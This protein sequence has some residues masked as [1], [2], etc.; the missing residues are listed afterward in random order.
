[1]LHRL[2]QRRPALTAFALYGVAVCLAFSPFW[3]GKFLIND[4]SDMRNGYAFRE[5]AADYAR[6]FGGFPEWNPYIFGGMPFLANPANGDTFYPTFLLRLVLPVDVGIT[7]GFML[8]IALA[9]LFTFLLLRAMRLE[10]GAAFVGGAAY[11]FGGQVLSLVSP[12][13]DGKLFVSALLPLALLC[14]YIGVIRADWRRFVAFG[15]VVG[16]SLLSP[17][18]QMTYYLLMASGFFLAYLQF[19]HRPREGL[20][21]WW[22]SGLFFVGALAIGFAIDAIQLLPFLE[23]IPFSPRGA[24]GRPSTGWEFATLFSMPPEELVN[25]VWPEFSGSIQSYWGRNP[26][27]LHSEYLGVAALLLA[28]F[29]FRAPER[30]PLAWFFVFV[31]AYALL[32]ALGGHTPFYRIPY[33]ILPGLKLTRAP[34]MIF[35]ITGLSVAVLA[36]FGAQALMAGQG[37]RR[38]PLVV[39]PIVLGVGALLA[40]SGAWEAPMRSLAGPDPAKAAVIAEHYKAFA[41]DTVRGLVVCLLAVAL[42]FALL[43]GRLSADAWATLM[44]ALVL[45][46]LWSVERHFIQFRERPAQS[47]AADDIVRALRADTSLYRLLPAAD[48][49]D[50]YWMV[51]RVRSTNGYHGVELHRYDDLLGGKNVW[52]NWGNPVVWQLLAVKYL[53][54]REPL[55]A[56]DLVP[57]AAN[58]VQNYQGQPV[59]FYRY[60][61]ALPWA[62]LVPEALKIPDDQALSVLTDPRFDP[63]RLLLVPADAPVG[64]SQLT[65]LPEPDS[66][67]VH[68]TATRPGVY[69]FEF[70]RPLARSAYL[71]VAENHY[72]AWRARV[73]GRDAPVLRAQHALMGIPVG[74]GTRHVDL[75]YFSRTYRT[76]R[77]V[78]LAAL[79]VT[80]VLLALG[81]RERRRRSV[82]S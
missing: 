34:S 43:R 81:W 6:R 36:A 47:Y 74:A 2:T 40:V 68:I 48:P 78:T 63:R 26:L 33:E 59:Y 19:F 46:D 27:K 65:A 13:H 72:L 3:T 76:G 7:L 67:P 25:V 79:G 39:W 60:A 73:D 66:T 61:R 44:A 35:Y 80:L 14:L 70:E 56:P 17:Q 5:F 62:Y 51:H 54:A 24:P 77:L 37:G 53:T 57:V 55:N 9:G 20:A 10:W 45:V 31:G 23:Y 52:R 32:F 1:M 18:Q 21:P 4:W 8:H 16:L 82:A 38:T 50:N 49:I 29:S 11:M 42:C 69:R 28:T 75:E 64:A 12:G 30:R 15:L 41:L 71:F 58:P 22:R